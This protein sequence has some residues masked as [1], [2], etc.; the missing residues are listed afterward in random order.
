MAHDSNLRRKG[1]SYSEPLRQP[2]DGQGADN[3]PLARWA[4]LIGQGDPFAQMSKRPQAPQGA[5]DPRVD[6]EHAPN[7]LVRP[8]QARGQADDAPQPPGDDYNEAWLPKRRCGL[9]TI[10]AVVGLA[11]FGTGA[12][13]AYLAWTDPATI[14]EPPVI[15]TE[16]SPT[17]IV[18]VQPSKGQVSKQAYD[19]VGNNT[20]G[21]RVV[22]HEEQPVDPRAAP[23]PTTPDVVGPPGPI[24]LP[25]PPSQAVPAAA[26]DAKRVTTVSSRADQPG[27]TEAPP[28]P[29]PPQSRVAPTHQAMAP[30]TSPR[31][32][33]TPG[34]APQVG[35]RPA[36][37]AGGY[38]VQVSSQRT[39]SEAQ[40]YYR[41]LQAKYPTV[42]GSRR[43]TI[44]RADLGEKGIFFRTQVGTFA[45]AKEAGEMCNSLKA[46]GG[47]CIVQ[48]RD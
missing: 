5:A 47:Q 28:A 36:H 32:L 24:T 15:N 26:G 46:A 29:T 17:K 43:P 20:G 9:T 7:W 40:A 41:A 11:L 6:A 34:Q 19:R 35:A 38:V 18:P 37:E 48:R 31:A 45:A 3:D 42:L 2:A 21:E 4:R 33:P 8:A 10:A 12:M 44:K 27:S 14:G 23:R 13:F 25:G 1:D 22:S 16:Q 30:T 39:E